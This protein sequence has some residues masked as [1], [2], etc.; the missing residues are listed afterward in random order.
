MWLPFIKHL[1]SSYVTCYT[2]NRLD[3]IY[4]YTRFTITLCD[5]THNFSHVLCF[6]ISNE[7]T[8]ILQI[9]LMKNL[10]H[11]RHK[12]K[13]VF[14]NWR[15]GQSQGNCILKKTLCLDACLCN[16]FVKNQGNRMGVQGHLHRIFFCGRFCLQ[17]KILPTVHLP[18]S[19]EVFCLL[20]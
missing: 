17:L 16:L 18:I 2:F 9:V 1:I 6:A 19:E 14:G 5:I 20:L 10:P 4:E 12:I 8:L 3:V 15:S 11:R 7:K 13:T